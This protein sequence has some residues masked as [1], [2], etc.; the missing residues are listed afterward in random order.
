LAAAL[1]G[2]SQ[3]LALVGAPVVGWACDRYDRKYIL[4]ITSLIGIVGFGGFGTASE[5]P[6]SGAAFLF[7]MLSGTSSH[8][9]AL[10][11]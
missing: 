5:A 9:L 10:T 7:S 11:R 6:R 3:L 2:T 8:F 1:T 4:V